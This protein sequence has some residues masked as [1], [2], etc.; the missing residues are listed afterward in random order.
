MTLQALGGGT[1]EDT[2]TRNGDK[3]ATLNMTH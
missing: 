1:E 3:V 2:R